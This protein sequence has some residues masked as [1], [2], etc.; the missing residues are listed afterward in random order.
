MRNA[1]INN[2]SALKPVII[3]LIGLVGLHSCIEDPT[4]ASLTTSPGINL[5][6]NTITSGGEITSDGGAAVTAKGVCWSTVTNPTIEGS[7]TTDGDGSGIFVSNITGLTPNTMYFLRAYA[8]NE[9]GITYGNEVVITT[10][11]AGAMLITSPVS[12]IAPTTAIS[13]GNITYDGNTAILERGVCWSTTPGPDISDSFVATGT[14]AGIFISNM[15]GLAQGTRYYVRAYAKNSAGIAYGNE[16]SFNTQV[17]DIEGNRYNTITIGTQIWMAENLRSTK[18]KNNT[19]IPYVTGDAAW[20]ALTTPAYCWFL[21]DI[22]K[23]NTYGA[24]YNWYTVSTGN[25]CP[26]GW[27]VPTDAEFIT[28]ETFLGMPA[29]Q[30]ELWEWRGTDQGTQMKTTTGWD[31]GGNGTN[32]SGFSAVSGGYRYGATGAFNANAILT[33]WWCADSSGEFGWYR[34]L[35]G[36]NK[37]IYRAFT[38][39]KGGKYVRCVKE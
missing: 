1:V 8:V 9:V 15:T 20:I 33:Y 27:H 22:E 6:I 29:A 2:Y 23:K 21:N 37:G 26:A 30:A 36:A 31:D 4:L 38:S 12:E 10:D 17:A 11:A 5:T 16:V 39:R 25:L 7:H 19:A 24:L 32:T 13:G 3:L 18:Y 35:D 14:G 28:L 34:R